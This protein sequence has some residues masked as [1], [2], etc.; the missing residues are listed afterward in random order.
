MKMF[1]S[2]I[3]SQVFLYTKWIL[4]VLALFTGLYFLTRISL[5]FLLLVFFFALVFV[6][7]I[8]GL[9]LV[10]RRMGRIRKLAKQLHTDLKTAIFIGIIL[11]NFPLNRA[12]KI[13]KCKWLRRLIVIG[14]F[15]TEKKKILIVSNHPAWLD[16]V[17][18]IQL[19][20]SYLEWLKNPSIFPY[21]GT[22]KDSIIRLPSLR[23]LEVF[24]VLTPIERKKLDEAALAEDTMVKI[25]GNDGNLIISGPA[26]RDFK[27]KE[28]EMIYSP[29][30]KKPL[31]KFGGLCGRLATLEGVMTV[32]VYIEGTDKLFKH[33]DNEK[34]MRFSWY[35]FLVRFL[36]LGKIR[37][38]F[39]VSEN[40]LFLAG[41]P[42]GEAREKIEEAVLNLA[43]KC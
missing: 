16:Q 32:P 42:K 28:K 31:R 30:K 24:N 4:P 34:E 41:L 25:L 1:H 17:T 35:N 39:V 3:L 20:L 40:P 23:F 37:I 5:W 33:V 15:P 11:T 18:L 38:I 19:F 29:Q 26:G 13:L 2:R 9:I 14:E 10:R 36:L 7:L 8:V 27:K 22:A 12:V 6:M 21:I 43:D